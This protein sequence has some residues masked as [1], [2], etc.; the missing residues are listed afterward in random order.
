MTA[1]KTSMAHSSRAVAWRLIALVVLCMA[2]NDPSLRIA[3]AVPPVLFVDQASA[4]CSDT[5]PGST[6]QPFCTIGAGASQA[7]AGQ[8]VSVSQGTYAENVTPAN[9]GTQQAPIV[10]TTTTG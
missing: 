5:G 6:S 4:N 1:V 9:S 10:F 2:T 7:V 3:A 8:T